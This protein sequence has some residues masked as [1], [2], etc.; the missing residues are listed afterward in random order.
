M[1]NA[2][3]GTADNPTPLAKAASHAIVGGAT[4]IAVK[5]IAGDVAAWVS[6]LIAVVVHALLD[7]P[8]ARLL[9]GLN[10]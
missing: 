5:K 1:M 10:F 4:W 3:F 6:A 7:A 2:P 9:G 8:I